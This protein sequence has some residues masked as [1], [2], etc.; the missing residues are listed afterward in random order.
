MVNFQ[1]IYSYFLNHIIIFLKKKLKL[2]EAN[3]FLSHLDQNYKNCKNETSV[4]SQ[5]NVVDTFTF[6]YQTE[7][8]MDV[9]K[10]NELILDNIPAS[11]NNPSPLKNNISYSEYSM[12]VNK[13]RN[14]NRSSGTKYDTKYG[15]KCDKFCSSFGKEQSSDISSN[16]NENKMSLHTSLNSI[17]HLFYS[18]SHLNLFDKTCIDFYFDNLYNVIN[19]KKNE[20]TAYQW[21]L[22]RDT[23]KIV[24]I[25]NK[26]E[27]NILLDNVNTY[28]NYG[29]DSK[30]QIETIHIDI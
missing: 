23:I 27:W 14:T 6:N 19:E 28:T 18:F 12:F 1:K 20:I 2:F 17:I 3:S 11:E 7:N 8:N 21:L 29:K 15:I 25:K 26:T 10:L 13:R 5:N 30:D 4:K 22:I 24:N 16:V 9:Q